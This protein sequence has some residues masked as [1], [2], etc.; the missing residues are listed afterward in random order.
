[1][2]YLVTIF[3]EAGDLIEWATLNFGRWT[4]LGAGCLFIG[5]SY[6]VSRSP[7]H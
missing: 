4:L 1:L 2:D 6:F 3:D 5:V 7:K